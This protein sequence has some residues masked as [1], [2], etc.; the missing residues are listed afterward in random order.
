[1]LIG[2][3][4]I[5]T[6]KQDLALQLDALDRATGSRAR[7]ERPTAGSGTLTTSLSAQRSDPPPGGTHRAGS[8]RRR[9]RGGKGAK[10][11]PSLYS[12]LQPFSASAARSVRQRRRTWDLGRA[13]IGRVSE[14]VRLTVRF[15]DAGEGWV[16]ATIPEVPGGISQSRRL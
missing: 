13:I 2:Y 16:L 14:T 8:R 4:R 12:L 11:G 5:S 6:G 10:R 7:L 1:M 9:V 3:A 15:E